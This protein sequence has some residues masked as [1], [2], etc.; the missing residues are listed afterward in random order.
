MSGRATSGGVLFQS[1]VGAYVAALLLTE[2]PISRLGDNL[3][4]KPQKIFMEAP[5]PVD[6][7]KVITDKGLLFFQAKTNLSLSDAKDSELRSVVDQFV[8]QYR[9][10]VPSGSKNRDMDLTTDR[11]ILV[12]SETAPA[13][14]R[15]DLKEVLAKSRTGAATALPKN[16]QNA[17]D[18]F[19]GLIKDAW[20]EE[21]GTAASSATVNSILKLCAVVV[22]DDNQKL[23][24]TEALREVVKIK[25]DETTLADMLV[26]WA[27]EASKNGTGGDQS[28]IRLYLQ[29]KISLVEP[30]SYHSDVAKL[31]A[32]SASV[33]NRLVRFTKINTEAGEITFSRPVS[34]VVISA[35]RNGGLAITGDPGS[36]K[37]GIMHA[38]SSELSKDSVVV[39]LTVETNI[40]TLEALQKEIG[41]EHPLI[42]VCKNISL[43]GTGYLVLDALDAT[44]GGVA[45]A[46]YKKLIHEVSLLPGWKVIASVRTFDLKL[47]VEWR[48][49]FKGVAPVPGFSEPSFMAVRHVHVPLLGESEI[50]EIEAKSPSLK[51]A[52]AAGGDKMS[53]LARNPFNLSLIGELLSAGVAPASLSGVVTRSELLARYWSERLDDLGL[54]A[55]IAMKTFVELVLSARAVDIPETEIPQDAAAVIQQLQ[56]RGVLVTEQ[57]H[58]I[59]FRH[60]VLFDYAVSKLILEP[61]PPKAIPRLSKS[62]GAGLLISPSLEYWVEHLK[63]TSSAEDYWKLITILMTSEATDPIIRVE[64]ARIAVQGVAVGEDLTALS[65][66][67]SGADPDHKKGIIHLAG[68]LSTFGVATGA[69]DGWAVM[70]SGI[71]NVIDYYQLNSLRVIIDLLL[72]GPLTDIGQLALGKVSRT[73]FDAMSKEDHLIHWLSPSVI[74]FLAKT[75]GSDPKASKDRLKQVFAPERFNKLGYIEVPWLARETVSLAEHDDDLIAMLYRRVFAGGDFSSEHKT[76]MGRP[77]WILSLTSNAAQDFSLA[78]YSLSTDFPRLLELFPKAGFRALGAGLDGLN[79][80]RLG[81]PVKD[82]KV[83]YLDGQKL[84]IEDNSALWAWDIDSGH[85]GE[86]KIYSAFIAW[87]I[88]AD[89]AVLF[90]APAILLNESSK[91]LVWKVLFDAATRRPEVLGKLM[92]NSA[93]DQVIL[94]SMNTRKQAIEMITAT[95]PLVSVEQRR[96]AEEKI[97]S[98]DFAH[99]GDPEYYLKSTV[100]TVFNAIGEANLVTEQAKDFLKK[101]LKDGEDV[102]NGRPVEFGSGWSSATS[103]TGRKPHDSDELEQIHSASDS[104]RSMMAEK[105]EDGQ[106]DPLWPTVDGLSKL[107]D[108]ASLPIPE[109]LA[110]EAAEVI[111]KSLGKSLKN[112]LV[113]TEEQD[114]AVQRLL[115]LSHHTSPRIDKQ[116]EADFERFPSWSGQSVR[117]EAAGAL[118]DTLT[119]PGLWPKISERY[120]KMLL[121]D[122]HP[123]VRMQLITKVIGLWDIDRNAMWELADKFVSSEHNKAVLGFGAHVLSRLRVIAPE[124]VEPLFLKLTG[125]EVSFHSGENVVPSTFAY[126]GVVKG[127]T[128][129]KAEI[130]KWIANF[131][132][133]EK[134]LHGVLFSLRDYLGIGYS[135]AG[136]PEEI[137]RKNVI[138]FLWALIAALEP[139][140]RSWPTDR[141]AT[142]EEVAALK[143]FNEIADQLYYG[144]GYRRAISL[145][146]EEQ[147]AFLDEYSP[148]ISKLTTL[149]TPKSVH[150]CLE[151]L[152]KLLEANPAQC[153][154]LFSEAMLRKTGVARYEHEPMGAKLFVKLVGLYIADYRPIFV[155]AQRREKLVECLAVFVEA[156]WPEARRLFQTLPEL[157]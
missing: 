101:A 120:Q 122:P 89:E 78:E 138:A 112:G 21:E 134:Q 110:D 86:D 140:V 2:R 116:T 118:G 144:I 39:T 77:S 136:G 20:L 82:Y 53:E 81:E 11:L 115:D 56:A 117:V 148:I 132:N 121:T 152:E 55:T 129:S 102:S 49:L 71:K 48:R 88:G 34:P 68:T 15:N 27:T 83:D 143:L 61:D 79:S 8:R 151:V 94:S 5:S 139:N 30:P 146:I 37:S 50:S 73:L 111:S 25:G 100:A 47:G 60:H 35:A 149:G 46:T 52:L 133:Y 36:G 51:V 113:P 90:T 130:G 84:F 57:T 95:Y 14:V 23:L 6:D 126:F 26:K 85:D 153:F 91:A 87:A 75:Y 106:E 107:V 31:T 64:V 137:S 42:E 135:S 32:Y 45:E 41:L 124:K 4:G 9:E 145:S 76:A 65:K 123:A 43:S 58:R 155:D 98:Y 13:T 104:L 1:E 12:V 17:L 22:L 28:A 147:Q 97:L 38:L 24:A 156:G 92:W 154:D 54:P 131:K 3:P 141:E 125:K 157:R 29:G 103:S 93:I 114:A 44:R 59:A 40:G 142:E 150:H 96:S 69:A 127:F 63:K 74:P 10:G 19:T 67:L 62:A 70:V 18:I 119:V 66:V 33:V 7:V 128:S 80:R 16:Q 72:P 99:T 109:A 108:T 105:V